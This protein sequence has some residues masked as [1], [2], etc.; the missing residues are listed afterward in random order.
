MLLT[1]SAR[2]NSVTISRIDGK[3]LKSSGSRANNAA[4]R[5]M[6]ASARL[7]TS[8][9]SSTIVGS[10]TTIIATTISRPT[11]SSTSR[12][13]ASR[14]KPDG[15]L[16]VGGRSLIA[17]AC[18]GTSACG[19]GRRPGRPARSRKRNARISAIAW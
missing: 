1:F 16:V 8:S 18:T 14:L 19:V 4:T 9:R 15:P 11:A 2:R 5:I 13:R 6:T 7:S 3:T 17:Y 12:C 10:G